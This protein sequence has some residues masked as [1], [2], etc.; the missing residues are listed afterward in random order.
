MGQKVL[1]VGHSLAVTIP[2][3]FCKAVGVKTGTD[4]K[5]DTI[6]EKGIISY[7][8]PDSQQQLLLT[9]LFGKPKK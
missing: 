8:F 7:H 5:V 9:D 1:K 6:I 2:S 3:D 4:V